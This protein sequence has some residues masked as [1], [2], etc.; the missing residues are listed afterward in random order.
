MM[1]SSQRIARGYAGRYHSFTM[2]RVLGFFVYH[3]EKSC[4]LSGGSHV[5]RIKRGRI[6]EFWV[7]MFLPVRPYRCGKARQRFYGQKKFSS[8]K[9]PDE[10]ADPLNDEPLASSHPP[11]SS[12]H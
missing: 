2:K 11:G 8:R 7:L 3:P 10:A 9:D 6:L 1:N 4:P 12:R 5:H